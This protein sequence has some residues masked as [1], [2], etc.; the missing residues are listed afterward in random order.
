MSSYQKIVFPSQLVGSGGVVLIFQYPGRNV[1]TYGPEVIG[2]EAMSKYG[3]YEAVVERVDNF[4]TFD[5]PFIAVGSDAAAWQTFL[6]YAKL[7]QLFDFYPD[8]DD[9]TYHVCRITGKVPGLLYSGKPGFMKLATLT[10]REE[11]T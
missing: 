11:I 10:L 4:I 1:S 2:D 8:L 9:S 7:R 5:M 6:D 3:D